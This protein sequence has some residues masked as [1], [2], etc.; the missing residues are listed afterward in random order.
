MSPILR[1]SYEMVYGGWPE[2]YDQ[3]VLVL[4]EDSSIPA[5]AG[6]ATMVNLLMRFYGSFW[7]RVG[8]MRSSITANLKGCRDH[9]WTD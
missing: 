6:K 3:V 7:P 2:Q 8:F 5:G 1:E 4:D 9:G